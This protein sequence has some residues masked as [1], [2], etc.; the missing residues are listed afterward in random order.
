MQ[1]EEG[2][3]ELALANL[4]SEAGVPWEAAKTYADWRWSPN[5]LPATMQQRF[6]AVKNMLL[7][8]GSELPE[9]HQQRIQTDDELA[10][11]L[12]A[13]ERAMAASDHAQQSPN[14]QGREGVEGVE[15]PNVSGCRVWGSR[16]YAMRAC[17]VRARV[18]RA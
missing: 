10:A 7:Q 18:M 6:L 4:L 8:L 5:G 14:S 16:S 9:G 11:C 13:A 3:P 15:G 2:G 12:Q 17:A 1:G